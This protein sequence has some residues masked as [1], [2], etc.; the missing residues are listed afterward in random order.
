[1]NPQILLTEHAFSQKVGR[2]FAKGCGGELIT[3]SEFEYGLCVSYG[4]LRGCGEAYKRASHYVHIDH[5][6]WEHL[7]W[8]NV[9]WDRAMFR[10]CVDS[11]WCP[12]QHDGSDWVKYHT[13]PIRHSFDFVEGEKVVVVPPSEHMKKY[14]GLENWLSETLEKL[15]DEDVIVSKKGESHI[16][17][18][19]PAKYVVTDHSNAAILALTQGTSVVFTN[20]QRKLGEI[21]NPSKD[22]SFFARLANSLFTLED[23]ESGEAWHYVEQQLSDTTTNH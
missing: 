8:R 11:L 12:S 6:Y 19:L 23:F 17:D 13:I 2:A 4:I 3:P 5:P 16:E 9:G 21:G 10:V 1:M 14:L 20:P 22:R 15:S 7:S 18:L